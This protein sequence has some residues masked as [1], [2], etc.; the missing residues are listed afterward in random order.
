VLWNYSGTGKWILFE[1]CPRL[2]PETQG[3]SPEAWKVFAGQ[4]EVCQK[5]RICKNKSNG[6]DPQKYL[7]ERWAKPSQKVE[8]ASAFKK[9]KDGQRPVRKSGW[10]SDTK[11][12]RWANKVS[13]KLKRV[14]NDS[15]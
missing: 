12:E 15:E 6:A 10:R 14:L 4:G 9:L 3:R 7:K 5:A 11:T 1:K 2:R 8:D 13:L